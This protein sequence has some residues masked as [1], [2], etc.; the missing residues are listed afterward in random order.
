MSVKGWQ[1]PSKGWQG[2]EG[3][4][5]GPGNGIATVH[6]IYPGPEYTQWV[7]GLGVSCPFTIPG[8]IEGRVVSVPGSG[9]GTS[10]IF[11]SG[12]LYKNSSARNVYLRSTHCF[13]RQSSASIL[14]SSSERPRLDA[15][16]KFS[17]IH[18]VSQLYRIPLGPHLNPASLPE[19]NEGGA[20]ITTCGGTTV[21]LFP[22]VA[23]A[24]SGIVTIIAARSGDNALNLAMKVT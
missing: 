5:Q 24:R 1:G 8:A 23:L 21:H 7:T 20:D 11:E 16:C 9:T 15:S 17:E 14:E 12:T 4:W 10:E 19:V 18:I 2:V 13:N 22:P 3:A 6:V